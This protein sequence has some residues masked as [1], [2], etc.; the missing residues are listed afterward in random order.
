MVEIFLKNYL[1]R[2]IQSV[3]LILVIY[4]PKFSNLYKL[5]SKKRDMLFLEALHYHGGRYDLRML[6]KG[7]DNKNIF[8]VKES[9]VLNGKSRKLNR[10]VVLSD[11]YFIMFEHK[12]DIKII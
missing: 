2:K 9:F 12:N 1:H 11:V 8:A 7:C 6:K 3:H 4:F 5:I 10:L